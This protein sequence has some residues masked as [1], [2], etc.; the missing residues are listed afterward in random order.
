MTLLTQEYAKRSLVLGEREAFLNELGKERDAAISYLEN[1]KKLTNSRASLITHETKRME[2]ELEDVLVKDQKLR[3]AITLKE[4]D[5]KETDE[6]IL[7]IEK[8]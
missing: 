5:V 4:N 7:D 3:D 8:K 6:K 2:T 1:K